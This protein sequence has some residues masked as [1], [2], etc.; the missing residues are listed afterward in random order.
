MLKNRKQGQGEEENSFPD[1]SDKM[2]TLKWEKLE[3]KT[4][5]FYLQYSPS[6]FVSCVGNIIWKFKL[7]YKE[8]RYLVLPHIFSL[9]KDLS[10]EVGWRLNLLNC[11]FLVIYLYVL[12]YIHTCEHYVCVYIWKTKEKDIELVLWPTDVFFL[13]LVIVKIIF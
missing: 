11:D 9:Q 4:I 12:I 6:K 3:K 5:R 7:M 1:F 2:V 8:Q 13:S 10:R